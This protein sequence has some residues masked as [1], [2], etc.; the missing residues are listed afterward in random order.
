[1]RLR[2]IISIVF[3]LIL[4]SVAAY[5]QERSFLFTMTQPGPNE[6]SFVHYDAAYGRQTFEPFGSDGVEQNLGLQANLGETLT[7]SAYLGMAL[8]GGAG[9]TTQQA[10]LLC[11]ILKT[12]DAGIDFSAGLGFRHEYSGTDVLLGRFIVGRRINQWDAYGNLIF[13]HAFA[14]NRDDIDLTSTLGLSREITNGV[15]LGVEAVG[16]DLEGFWTPDEAEGGAVVFIGPDASLAFPGTPWSLVV[17]GG[18][19][20]RATY[21]PEGSS[22]LRALPEPQSNG[23]IVRSVLSYGF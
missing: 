13:E 11:R 23:F 16:Q 17:G 22:A 21:S 14:P 9:E 3:V 5:A 19:I 1:M 15:R 2:T 10:E 18:A 20:I 6:P 8:N 12:T 4:C 7:L